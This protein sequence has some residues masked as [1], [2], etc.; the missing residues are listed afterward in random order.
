M[1]TAKRMR[2]MLITSDRV[3]Y[4]GRLG[5]PGSRELG[6]LTLY[7]SLDNPFQIQIGDGPWEQS[8]MQAVPPGT[9]HQIS[10]VDPMI[11]S[12]MIE[13]EHLDTGRLPDFLQAR[14]STAESRA[15]LD[16]FRQAC[17]ALIEGRVHVNAIR[18]HIDQFLLGQTL[19]ARAIESRI[20]TVVNRIK[21]Q[22]CDCVGAEGFAEQVD[23]SFSRFLHLFKA[24]VGITF[25]RFRAWKRARSFLALVNTELNLTDI[26][27]QTG[28]PDSSHFS[29]TVRRCWGLTPSDMVAGSRRLAVVNDGASMVS[30]LY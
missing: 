18:S 23:L 14:G 20:A 19:P 24:E 16:H 21:R 1:D 2:I 9:R 26:A 3:F 25:R 29:H 28:Y 6:S 7:V 12:L 27:Y 11:C 5:Q 22:P 10:T 4:A 13:P 8:E 30:M 17:H 15:V